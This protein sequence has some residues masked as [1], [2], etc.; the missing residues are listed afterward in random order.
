ML[1]GI[2][3][4]VFIFFQGRIYA[5]QS[6]FSHFEPV[7][8]MKD[9]VLAHKEVY[10]TGSTES[11]K[12]LMHP[13]YAEVY[14]DRKFDWLL[15]VR[16]ES[17]SIVFNRLDFQ[18]VTAKIL[19]WEYPK[20][21]VL[22]MLGRWDYDIDLDFL[23]NG[24]LLFNRKTGADNEMIISIEKREDGYQAICSNSL[25]KPYEVD[26]EEAK[27]LWKSFVKGCM[28]E[29]FGKASGR[30]ALRQI[31]GLPQEQPS[32]MQESTTSG[33]IN[34]NVLDEKISPYFIFDRDNSIPRQIICHD[35]FIV[36]FS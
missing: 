36:N 28:E 27:D 23:S 25:V 16:E 19:D 15:Q 32:Q 14:L 20:P 1:R 11:L 17:D 12:K 3:F 18:F 33:A 22:V 31:L 6:A 35:D 2:V 26:P 13:G 5:D 24:R 4:L 9:F 34:L 10:Q 30:E 7:S 21:N 29:D 8:W